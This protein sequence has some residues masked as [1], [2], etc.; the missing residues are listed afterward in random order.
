MK[1]YVVTFLK[2]WYFYSFLKGFFSLPTNQTWSAYCTDDFRGKIKCCS[3]YRNVSGSCEPCI[4]SFGVD[5]NTTCLEGFYGFGCKKKCD[6]LP[7]ES[8]HKVHGC[9]DCRGS[10][11]ENCSQSCPFGFYGINCLEKCNCSS[12]THWCD[13]IS[14]CKIKDNDVN[15]GTQETKTKHLAFDVMGSIIGTS[16]FWWLMYLVC[17]WKQ[18]SNSTM[19]VTMQEQGH[20]G[21]RLGESQEQ[22]ERETPEFGRHL[23]SNSRQTID[24]EINADSRKTITHSRYHSQDTYGRLT[25]S[26]DDFSLSN[27]LEHHTQPSVS[28]FSSNYNSIKLKESHRHDSNDSETFPGESNTISID[29]SYNVH[30]SESE[31]TGVQPCSMYKHRPYSSVKYNRKYNRKNEEE[32]AL[33]NTVECQVHPDDRLF[34]QDENA[35]DVVEDVD[36]V[37]GFHR[38]HV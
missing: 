29:T 16:A 8:C 26:S 31:I 19:K 23:R 2:I 11:G 9:L 21:N 5:C 28:T 22:T 27:I 18:R 13:N 35:S 15:N 1:M 4:G 34:N 32:P 17:C 12:D 37:Y 14:G 6:C 24:D 7:T 25:G 38:K 33:K 30:D 20:S 3:N 36:E 10:F